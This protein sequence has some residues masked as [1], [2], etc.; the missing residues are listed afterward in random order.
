M[1]SFSF[2]GY[3][4][5]RQEENKVRWRG[6]LLASS[7]GRS[8]WT[9]A[10]LL[11]RTVTGTAITNCFRFFRFALSSEFSNSIGRELFIY[12]FQLFT[13]KNELQVV[14]GK[15]NEMSNCFDE[16]SNLD[17]F[18]TAEFKSRN[19]LTFE[20]RKFPSGFSTSH[21]IYWRKG[22]SRSWE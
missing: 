15:V 21:W 13:M 1:S 10:H 9:K 7:P 19:L 4:V 2:L 22:I 11:I 6:N 5:A 18:V 3:W 14:I 8:S 16:W 20:S 17:M 12:F